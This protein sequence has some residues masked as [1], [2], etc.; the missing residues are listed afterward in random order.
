MIV[1]ND[2]ATGMLKEPLGEW[3]YQVVAARNGWE[4]LVLVGRRPVDGMLV[5]MDMPIM[6]GRTMLRELR[7]LGY[8]IPVLMMSNESDEKVHRQLLMEGAQGFFLKPPHLQS[9]QQTCRQVFKS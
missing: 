5:D 1:S 9:L 4:A 7:W 2:S 3:G 8:Q 6:D